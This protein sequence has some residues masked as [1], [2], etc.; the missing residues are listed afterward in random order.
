MGPSLVSATAASGL[1]RRW[2]GHIASFETPASPA[3]QDK[4]FLYAIYEPV[5]ILRSAHR[6]RLEGRM[7]R[8]QLG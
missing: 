8:L 4:V 2:I 3:P 6:A 1:I 5:L 7:T